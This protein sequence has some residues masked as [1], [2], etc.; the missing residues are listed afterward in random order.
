MN[1]LPTVVATARAASAASSIVPP[2]SSTMPAAHTQHAIGKDAVPVSTISTGTG[3]VRAA[4]VA[5]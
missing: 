1:T 3:E 5:D 2:R 4:S